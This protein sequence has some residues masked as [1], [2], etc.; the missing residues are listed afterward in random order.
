MGL[1]MNCD[2]LRPPVRRG[3][4]VL[5]DLGPPEQA[6]RH[7]LVQVHSIGCPFQI[8]SS[9]GHVSALSK[10]LIQSNRSTVHLLPAMPTIVAAGSVTGLTT[11]GGLS[12]SIGRNFGRSLNESKI[13]S[14]NRNHLSMRVSDGVVVR[15][16]A[17]CC[18]K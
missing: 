17:K 15:I 13:T 4:F 8:D 10:D 18:D 9:F 7:N 3:R 6:L 11:R 5:S 2:M 1:G 12:V 16:D 14:R